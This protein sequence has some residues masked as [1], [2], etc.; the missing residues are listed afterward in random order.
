MGICVGVHAAGNCGATGNGACFF[1]DGH[2]HPFLRL[3]GGTHPLARRTCEPWPLVQAGQIR[4]APLAG[5]IRPGARPTD[6]LA[7]Q[8]GRRQPNRRSGRD[9]GSRRYAPVQSR[10]G[11]PR[12]KH[13]P[14]SPCRLRARF[15]ADVEAHYRTQ[16]S[17]FRA[18]LR[19]A[20]GRWFRRT[21]PSRRSRVLDQAEGHGPGRHQRPACLLLGQPVQAMVEIAGGARR[22]TPRT[23][24]H[25]G[26][27]SAISTDAAAG[28]GTGRRRAPTCDTL[29]GLDGVQSVDL[30]I[31]AS[32]WTNL[33]T[34]KS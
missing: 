4:P 31:Y 26:M 27:R 7:G 33:R 28:P 8:P 19:A 16:I 24:V 2:S 23:G 6:R 9:P 13:Y 25:S 17:R 1:Y 32:W 10:S 18:D 15:D 12:Q 11:K 34:N 30:G 21:R 29:A 20:G 22:G 14:Q 5:A 3:R